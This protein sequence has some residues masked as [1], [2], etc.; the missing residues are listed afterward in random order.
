MKRRIVP[1]IAADRTEEGFQ[2]FAECLDEM[3][4]DY[5]LDTYKPPTHNASTIASE[6]LQVIDDIENEIIDASHL[7][8]LLQ[9][10]QCAIASDVVAKH[11]IDLRHES[12]FSDCT[13]KNL[14]LTRSKVSLV[15]AA[16]S[17]SRYKNSC[18]D[19]LL[20]LCR[21][22]R[23]KKEIRSVSRNLVATLLMGGYTRRHLRS[24]LTAN[25][26]QVG[27]PQN[28]EAR[29][30]TFFSELDFSRKEYSVTFAASNLLRF[31]D[32]SCADVGL[33]VLSAPPAY[34]APEHLRRMLVSG[35]RIFA[36]RSTIKAVDPYAAR[37]LADELLNIISD[38]FSVFHHT[39]VVCWSE[40]AVV[41]DRASGETHLIGSPVRPMARVVDRYPAI[42]GQRLHS[43]INEFRLDQASLDQFHRIVALHGAATRSA[44][45]NVQLLNLW[46]AMECSIPAALSGVRIRSVISTLMPYLLMSYPTSIFDDLLADIL[47]HNQIAAIRILKSAGRTGPNHLRLALADV[48]LL[49]ECDV[50]RRAINDLV[51]SYPLLANRCHVVME[52]FSSPRA[53]KKTLAAHESRIEWQ[54]RRVYR[55]R[56]LYIHSGRD[57]RMTDSLVENA[58][59]YLDSFVDGVFKVSK[60][61]PHIITLDQ[62]WIVAT[63]RQRRWASDI[64]AGQ[65]FTPQNIASLLFGPLS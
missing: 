28:C 3:L 56:N 53:L 64:A 24:R 43:A 33:S 16:L 54:I 29:L 30:R 46:S 11:L 50:E 39:Q 44:S 15:A 21:E 63:E 58:H 31:L 55:T 13:A 12:L 45:I 49:G 34:V 6:M 40:N 48:M 14:A 59:S 23:D 5:T 2:F 52:R 60:T 8:T 26:L 38:L 32:K 61:D 1:G 20:R 65:E 51:A 41:L 22:G 36:E 25:M 19:E 62:A 42:A 9:E 57:V 10:L 47:R 17:P 18:Q 4:F 37:K 35:G 27:N 7:E